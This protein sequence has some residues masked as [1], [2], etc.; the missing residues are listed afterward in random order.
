MIRCGAKQ[1]LLFL[2]CDCTTLHTS[3]SLLLTTSHLSNFLIFLFYLFIFTLFL[4]IIIIII[5]ITLAFSE[6]ALSALRSDNSGFSKG[7][8]SQKLTV[9]TCMFI[10]FTVFFSLD[11]SNL[12]D[13]LVLCLTSFCFLYMVYCFL[14]NFLL[15]YDDALSLMKSSELRI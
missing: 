11:C 8:R 14:L 3:L 6:Q 2:V 9:F 15:D 10:F 13:Y 4:I 1:T 7:F 12:D 5:I